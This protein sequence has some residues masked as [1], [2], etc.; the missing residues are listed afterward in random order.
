MQT[1]HNYQYRLGAA[2][3]IAAAPVLLGRHPRTNTAVRRS[4][5][6]N[7]NLIA[8]VLAFQYEAGRE[9]GRTIDVLDH[10]FEVISGVTLG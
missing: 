3:S 6:L 1:K 5:E 7:I 4:I 9:Y 10:I 2:G 8:T